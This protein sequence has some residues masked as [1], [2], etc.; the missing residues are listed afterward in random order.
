M[1][2]ELARVREALDAERELRLRQSC[3][4]EQRLSALE[5]LVE[6]LTSPR[7]LS[8]GGRSTN[9]DCVLLEPES[10]TRS[11]ILKPTRPRVR[12]V[13]R[14]EPGA[15]KERPS[16]TG[17][18]GESRS[19]RVRSGG[20]GLREIREEL[21]VIR[22]ECDNRALLVNLTEA[23]SHI[24]ARVSRLPERVAAIPDRVRIDRLPSGKW[25][26]APFDGTVRAFSHV[27]LF[28]VW[29]GPGQVTF[30]EVVTEGFN[31]WT[32]SAGDFLKLSSD[33]WDAR[34]VLMLIS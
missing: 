15:P 25:V 12:R 17:T 19:S 2:V 4:F 1:M 14:A 22:A 9:S 10:E 28:E 21:R 13:V 6:R 24:Q 29:R 33:A 34:P 3:E 7:E 18:S 23:V 16:T 27:A 30:Q 5:I 8:L 20:D 31:S 26:R 32:V 11:A